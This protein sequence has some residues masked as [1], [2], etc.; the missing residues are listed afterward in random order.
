M[1]DLKTISQTELTIFPS[2]WLGLLHHL[3]STLVNGTINDSAFQSKILGAKFD[4]SK[5]S[6]YSVDYALCKSIKYV[7]LSP[8]LLT[9]SS[10][11][12]H[13]FYQHQWCSNHLVVLLALFLSS[14]SPIF[15][16]IGIM[17]ILFPR[18]QT[19]VF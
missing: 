1:E 8:F 9:Y 14:F 5:Q 15:Y 3:L 12:H 18:E 4:S 16:N 13:T 10:P 7:H 2:C 19:R 11:G 17:F 6:I